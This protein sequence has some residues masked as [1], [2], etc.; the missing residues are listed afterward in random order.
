MD[1]LNKH[2]AAVL[3]MNHHFGSGGGKSKYGRM[4]DRHI[5][6]TPNSSDANGDS[7]ET[8]QLRECLSNIGSGLTCLNATSTGVS[9]SAYLSPSNVTNSGASTSVPF[10]SS[11]PSNTSASTSASLPPK[12]MT[13]TGASTNPPAAPNN[14]NTTIS[15]TTSLPNTV[16]TNN[17]LGWKIGLAAPLLVILVII[18]LA[19]RHKMIKKRNMRDKRQEVSIAH[20][21]NGEKRRQMERGNQKEMRRTHQRVHTEDH[22]QVEE[23]LSAPEKARRKDS[24]HEEILGS[25]RGSHRT[26]VKHGDEEEGRVRK[27]SMVTRFSLRSFSLRPG[28]PMDM[29]VFQ[30]RN[31]APLDTFQLE[32]KNRERLSKTRQAKCPP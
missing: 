13:N 16:S 17:R 11:S 21:Y 7:P 1:A 2:L 3:N 20:D 5:K 12:N 15:P 6:R 30:A 25:E 18:G 10:A 8:S 19:I 27:S 32:I 29:S 14:N 28:P 24:A 22:F 26:S 9:N 4:K 31:D 23:I